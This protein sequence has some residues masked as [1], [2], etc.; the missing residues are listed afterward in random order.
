MK[1][2]LNSLLVQQVL[3]PRPSAIIHLGLDCEV[4]VEVAEDGVTGIREAEVA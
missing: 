2:L 4:V 3:V 1:N